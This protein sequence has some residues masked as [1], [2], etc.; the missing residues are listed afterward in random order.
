P[1]I[2]PISPVDQT[3]PPQLSYG[4]P[5]AAL[6][7]LS[8]NGSVARAFRMKARLLAAAPVLCLPYPWT[9]TRLSQKGKSS[10]PSLGPVFPTIPPSPACRAQD[11][12]SSAARFSTERLQ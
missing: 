4:M 3:Q 6:A 7:K 10:G 11:A 8:S 5:E 9:V 12:N 2:V 1:P